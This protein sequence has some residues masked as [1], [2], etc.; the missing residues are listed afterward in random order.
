MIA[1]RRDDFSR[2]VVNHDHPAFSLKRQRFDK[3]HQFGEFLRGVRQFPG[4][5]LVHHI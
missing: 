4:V 2:I 5:R 1:V 3:I